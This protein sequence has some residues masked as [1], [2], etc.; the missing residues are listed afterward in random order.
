M[1]TYKAP[2]G[3][4]WSVKVQLHSTSN[5]L[6]LFRHPDGESSHR[7]RYNWFLSDGPESKNVTTSV[8]PE[9]V[10]AKLDP[11]T[12]ARLFGRSVAVSRPAVTAT[13]SLGL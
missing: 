5:A 6:V 8:T 13:K 9:A 4:E 10:E 1:K 11:A 12:L 2:D 3:T 7:D